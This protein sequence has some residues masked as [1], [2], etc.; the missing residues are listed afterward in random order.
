MPN[1][2]VHLAHLTFTN[3]GHVDCYTTSH[4]VLDLDDAAVTFEYEG[5][6]TVFDR[7]HLNM[8]LQL[9]DSRLVYASFDESAMTVAK[10]DLL[11][12]AL[13]VTV[14]TR[15]DAERREANLRTALLD[16]SLDVLRDE[17]A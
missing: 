16:A 9:N 17:L 13:D 8:T 6:R 11:A 4:D 7:K 3:G 2:H 12:S 10:R 5:E 14:E 1:T 15:L